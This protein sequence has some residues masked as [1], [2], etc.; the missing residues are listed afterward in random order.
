MKNEVSFEKRKA[1][2]D[3]WYTPLERVKTIEKYIPKDIT[4][5]CPFDTEQSYFV[6]ELGGARTIVHSHIQDGR[7]FFTYMPSEH[8]DCIVSNPPYS[9][10]NAV[11]KRL[12]E[13]G[14]PFAM[15]MNFNGLF[16]CK[17][18]YE[19]F[20]KHGVQLLIPCGRTNFYSDYAHEL[21]ATQPPFQAVYVCWQLLDKDIVFTD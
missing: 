17:L 21:P 18:R 20:K 12:F 7:D 14:K 8:F 2:T 13:I 9:K 15:L 3:E 6:K 4:V 10:R 5:W 19:L 16:D 11:Y 1:Q